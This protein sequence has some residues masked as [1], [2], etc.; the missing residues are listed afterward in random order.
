MKLIVTFTDLPSDII[1]LN[2][3]TAKK[4]ELLPSSLLKV[5]KNTKNHYIVGKVLI[6]SQFIPNNGHIGLGAELKKSFKEGEEVEVESLL[7]TESKSIIS[8]M[9][10]SQN[11]TEDEIKIFCIFNYFK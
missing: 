6:S 8:K 4:L 11:L 2:F 5:V 10:H 1:V 7:A 9:L 3:E